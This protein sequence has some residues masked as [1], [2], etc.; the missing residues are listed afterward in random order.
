MY[1]NEFQQK[2]LISSVDGTQQRYFVRKG[3]ADSPCMIYLH[4]HGSSGDQLMKRR[5]VAEFKTSFLVRQ[6]FSVIS[7]DLRGN[8]WMSEAAVTDLA[9]IIRTEK[10]LL[11]WNR[12]LITAGSMGGTGALIF[13]VCHPELVDGLAVFGAATDLETYCSFLKAQDNPGLKT[14]LEAIEQSYPTPESKKAH[15]ACLHADKLTVPIWYLHGG[16]DTV[17]PVSEAHA[18]VRRMAGCPN[19]HYREIAGGDHDAPL[20][21]YVETVTELLKSFR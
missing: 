15:S 16:S 4:G 2:S 14:I 17:I 20:P 13:A 8:A 11:S 21:Y 7:P 5:D 18:L 3:K 19:F 9:D 6:D 10:P 12:L 1:E